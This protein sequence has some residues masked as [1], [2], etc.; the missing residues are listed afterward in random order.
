MK[1]EVR[2][3]FT[4]ASAATAAAEAAS[5]AQT[6]IE[7]GSAAWELADQAYWLCRAAQK[8][9]ENSANVLDPEAALDD[10]TILYAH[11]TALAAAQSACSAADELVTLAM[12]NEHIIRR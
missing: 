10:D 3:A 4:A 6:M 8:A 11:M 7:A 5:K 9:A 1:L 2:L 12:E